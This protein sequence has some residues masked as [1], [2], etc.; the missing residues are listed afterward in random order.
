MSG[1]VLSEIMDCNRL[2]GYGLLHGHS[3]EILATISMSDD[4]QENSYHGDVQREIHI[5]VISIISSFP[6]LPI[7]T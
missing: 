2:S 7:I 5:K 1:C 6:F 4:D 3:R